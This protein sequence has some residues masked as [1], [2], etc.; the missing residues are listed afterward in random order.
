[1]NFSR[2]YRDHIPGALSLD[3]PNAD[4][5]I[6]TTLANPVS[7]YK[8]LGVIIDPQVMLVSPT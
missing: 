7:S 1:M 3:K 2:S 8:Y 4:G 6:T 5:T